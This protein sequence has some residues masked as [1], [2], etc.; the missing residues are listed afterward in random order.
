MAQTTDRKETRNII[1]NATQRDY[2]IPSGQISK[3]FR[4]RGQIIDFAQLRNLLLQNVSRNSTRTYM[5]YAKSNI[6]TYLRSPYTNLDNIRE[7]SRFL[8]RVS[9]IY[10]KIIEYTAQMPLYYYNVSYKYDFTQQLDVETYKQQYYDLLKR[11]QVMDLKKEF[12]TITATAIRDGIFNGFVYD[13]EE[14]GFMIHALDPRYCKVSGITNEGQYII[15]FNASYFDSGNNTEYLYGIDD[16][17]EGVWDQVFIEG[18]ETYKEMGNDY[19]WFELPP[20][21]TICVVAGDDYEMPLPY[22]VNLFISLMDLIDLEQI[23]ADKTE[24]ENYVLLVSKIPLIENSN[25]VDDFAVSLDMVRAT[26]SLINEAVPSLVGTAFTPCE[27]EVITFNQSDQSEDTDKLAQSMSNLFS[28]MGV[29]ELVVSGGKSTNT[30]G[31][32][33]SIQVDEAFALRF[34]DKYESWMNFYIKYNITESAI[35]KFHPITYFSEKEYVE[36]L[37]AAAAS[38]LPVKTDYATALGKTPFEMYSDTFTEEALG[39]FD[40]WKPLQ[41]SYTISSTTDGDTGG[42]P[43]GEEGDLS[44]EGERSREQRI[45]SE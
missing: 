34:V 45:Q 41:T 10:K 15:S 35:F 42:A 37:A 2:N 3:T 23:L 26:Q 40:L 16:N 21:R 5:Q 43:E 1:P 27:L 39:L 9:M 33:H 32:K 24:L 22:Y 38:G 29:T 8:Y 6:I 7:V 4:Q 25:E 20:E 17:G 18:Y 36:K 44:P 30:T 31:L 19:R 13:N 14:E 12:S 11:L 28:N